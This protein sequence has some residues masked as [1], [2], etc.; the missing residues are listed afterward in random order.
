MYL[1]GGGISFEHFG[2][3][4]ARNIRCGPR[5]APRSKCEAAAL[6]GITKLQPLRPGLF[7][8]LRQLFARPVAPILAD[9]PPPEFFG[10]SGTQANLLRDVFG[11]PFRLVIF[12]ASWRTDTVLALCT[13]D[14][15]VPRLL[16]DADTRGRT[17]GRRVR[18][19]GHSRSLPRTGVTRPGVL[20]GRSRVGEG[21][22][23][24]FTASVGDGLALTIDFC[25]S[26]PVYF[27]F[28]GSAAFLYFS[29]SAANRASRASCCRLNVAASSTA[30]VPRPSAARALLRPA[31]R[32][33]RGPPGGDGRGPS[34]SEGRCGSPRRTV[35]SACGCTFR[36]SRSH[37]RGGR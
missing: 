25:T 6:L 31:G 5:S 2:H 8:R 13:A 18:R 7:G 28:G 24:P 36:G 26:R 19:R 37:L 11:N 16:R 17:S 4:A 15:R 3:E 33:Q 27:P 10:N 32:P 9:D 14:V 1:C 20:G 29:T 35:W 12:S 21:M 34:T 23:Y 22:T 30:P